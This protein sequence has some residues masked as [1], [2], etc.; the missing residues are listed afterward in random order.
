MARKDSQPKSAVDWEDIHYFVVFSKEKSLSGAAQRLG[1]DHATIAR[2]IAALEA[3]LQLELVDRRA[4]AYVL[5]ADGEWVAALGARMQTG[6]HGIARAGRG[7]QRA[8]TGE[9]SISAPPVMATYLLAPRLSAL[10]DQHPGI[11]LRLVGETRHVSL[12]REMDL[13][14]RLSRPSEA[15]LVSRKIGTVHFS[16]YASPSY[17][18]NRDDA[19][20]E[21]IAYD[22]SMEESGQQRWLKAKAGPRPIVFRS[23]NLETQCA[24]AR[25]GVGIA[26]LPHFLADATPGLERVEGTRESLTRDVWLCVHRDLR[27][28]PAIR[29][30][31]DFLVS[32]FTTAS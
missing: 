27:R 29:A 31:M 23:N 19:E 32:C 8:L 28:S 10:R 17:L 25:G 16:L 24:A 6:A 15:E 26:A 13:A 7:R 12:H 21:F 18:A 1:V 4:R 30:V 11:R 22:T 20:L 2:R 3:S 5:T 9:V 14:L